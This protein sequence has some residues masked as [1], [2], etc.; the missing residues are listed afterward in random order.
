MNYL[1]ETLQRIQ[2]KSR[3]GEDETVTYIYKLH[4][5]ICYKEE[6]RHVTVIGEG[7]YY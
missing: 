1:K 6:Q 3:Q 5:S 7:K 4:C 2:E